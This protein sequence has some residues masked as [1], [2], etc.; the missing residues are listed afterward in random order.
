MSEM[1][2][3]IFAVIDTNVLVSAL[4]SNTL[5][6]NPVKV[7][8]AVIQE[9]I[10]PLFN[11][12]ILNEYREVLT[13]SKFNLDSKTVENVIKAFIED[14]LNLDRT[15]ANS[16]DFP[17]VKD[18]VFYE[19]TLSKE[20]SYLVTG[21]IKHFPSKPFVVTPAEMVALLEK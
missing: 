2:D 14:G 13:R 11:D 1:Q 10:I 5:D 21:N 6:S 19:V 17:D 12:E 4:I 18:I 15:P 9:N 20:G 16:I 8:R 3:K 7:F